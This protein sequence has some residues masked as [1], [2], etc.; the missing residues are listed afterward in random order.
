MLYNLTSVI[1]WQATK[2]VDGSFCCERLVLHVVQI[3]NPK[4]GEILKV[5]EPRLNHFLS[6]KQMVRMRS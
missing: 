4:K 6:F 1:S 5:N 2:E 3:I